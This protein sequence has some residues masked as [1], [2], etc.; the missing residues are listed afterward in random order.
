ML[1]ELAESVRVQAFKAGNALETLREGIL[2]LQAALGEEGDVD[3]SG[4]GPLAVLNDCYART[5]KMCIAASGEESAEGKTI[6][7][8]LDDDL[9]QVTAKIL[10]EE[11]QPALPGIAEIQELQVALGQK[12]APKKTDAAPAKTRKPRKPTGEVATP[13]VAPGAEVRCKR[14]DS[15]CGDRCG[16]TG[17]KAETVGQNQCPECDF[18]VEAITEEAP[19]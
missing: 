10:G 9:R 19:A 8:G 2:A 18:A 13:N 1:E 15:G 6:R 7:R 12:R 4:D 17:M 11:E 3:L 14:G 16:W 5:A